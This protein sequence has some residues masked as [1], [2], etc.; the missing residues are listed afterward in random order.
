MWINTMGTGMDNKRTQEALADELLM[1][2]SDPFT[3]VFVAALY[4]RER[5]DYWRALLRELGE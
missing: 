2:M 3:R 1:D 4:W 5:A